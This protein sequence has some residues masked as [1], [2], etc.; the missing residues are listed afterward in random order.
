MSR[1]EGLKEK[2]RESQADLTLSGQSPKQG[3]R[4]DG[5]SVGTLWRE[6]GLMGVRSQHVA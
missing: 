6:R 5:L 3:T 1:G 4:G 2:E